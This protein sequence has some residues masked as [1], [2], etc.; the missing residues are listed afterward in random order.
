HRE[1]RRRNR[2]AGEPEDRA[3]PRGRL[4]EQRLGIELPPHSP[5]QPIGQLGGQL[6]EVDRFHPVARG[7]RPAPRRTPGILAAW[8]RG[9]GFSWPTL[10]RRSLASRVRRVA[11]IGRRR[12]T[13]AAHGANASARLPRAIARSLAPPWRS[14]S[15]RSLAP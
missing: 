11:R 13:S 1:E 4:E 8:A 5:A 7:P 3:R 10:R 14:R 6:V 12:G 15:W 9:R 2:A